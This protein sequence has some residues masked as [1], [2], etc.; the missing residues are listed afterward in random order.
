[1]KIKLSLNLMDKAGCI[2]SCS[3]EG[4]SVLMN[5]YSAA[6][7]GMCPSVSVL[8]RFFLYFFFLQRVHELY[9]FAY[10]GIKARISARLGLQV[11]RY[12][13]AYSASRHLFFLSLPHMPNAG[14]RTPGGFLGI[15]LIPLYSRSI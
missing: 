11:E 15:P 14:S 2:Y 8:E 10:N 6:R 7:K 4:C 13:A 3:D 1:M 12:V 9:I 5:V